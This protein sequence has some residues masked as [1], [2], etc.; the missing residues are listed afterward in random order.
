MFWKQAFF[1]Y[2]REILS[3]YKERMK[4]TKKKFKIACDLANIRYRKFPNKSAF[5]F[6][7]L[8]ELNL[9]D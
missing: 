6:P 4:I 2:F 3:V 1:A 8:E 7:K 9:M 5:R